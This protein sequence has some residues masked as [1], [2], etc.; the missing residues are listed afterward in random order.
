MGPTRRCSFCHLTF[1]FVFWVFGVAMTMEDERYEP[2]KELGI[3]NFGVAR[4]IR[5]RKT[6]ELVAVKYIERGRKV[7]REFDSLERRQAVLLILHVW[8]DCRL[9][10]M[11]RGRS[12]TTGRC[13][14][15]TSSG[16]RR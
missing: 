15:P 1:C 11:F 10:R 6:G 9:T 14:I 12:L 2:V 3:G 5:E 7:K 4:L 8:C 16:L 13:G